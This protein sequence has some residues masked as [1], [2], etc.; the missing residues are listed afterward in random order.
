M[1]KIRIALDWTANTNHTG[2]YV[3]QALGFYNEHGL[4][5]EIITPDADDYAVTPGKKGRIGTSG[6]CPLSF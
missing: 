3:A 2:F 6:F 4:E 5:V 1:E